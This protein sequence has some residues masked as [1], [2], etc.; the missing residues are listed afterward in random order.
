MCIGVVIK[1]TEKNRVVEITRKRVQ[2][3]LEQAQVL[4][5]ASGGGTELNIV[6]IERLNGTMHQR[7]ASLTR[8]CWH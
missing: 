8:K 2:A 1:R 5:A 7:L 3:T 4:L 6:F